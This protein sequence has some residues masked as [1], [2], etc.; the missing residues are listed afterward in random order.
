MLY[1]I[2]GIP[3]ENNYCNI[4]GLLIFRK[5]AEEDENVDPEEVEM[6]TEEPEKTPEPEPAKVDQASYLTQIAVR[7]H[8]RQVWQKDSHILGHILGLLS[9]QAST[10]ESVCPTDLFFLD[11]LPVPPARFRPVSSHY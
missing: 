10:E 8:L 5:T 9:G 3:D 7:N 11:V 6:D 2:I 1:T 4:L